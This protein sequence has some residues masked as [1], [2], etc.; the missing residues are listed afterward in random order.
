MRLT[1]HEGGGQGPNHP[2]PCHLAG[3]SRN[4]HFIPSINVFRRS[5]EDLKQQVTS[6]TFSG[7]VGKGR[8]MGA[9]CVQEAS[10][11]GTTMVA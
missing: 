2:L 5:S 1:R 6:F 9:E 3:M 4:L 11:V 10:A 7:C 8:G